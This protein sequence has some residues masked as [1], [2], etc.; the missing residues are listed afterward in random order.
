[1]PRSLLDDEQTTPQVLAMIVVIAHVALL[2]AVFVGLTLLARSSGD[3]I[4][5]VIF[6]GSWL[7]LVSS[8]FFARVR[9]YTWHRNRRGGGARYHYFVTGCFSLVWRKLR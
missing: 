8:Y 1:M 9:G 5:V 6:L 4:C 2:L 7:T 3:G